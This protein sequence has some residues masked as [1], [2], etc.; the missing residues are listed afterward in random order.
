MGY[1]KRFADQIWKETPEERKER[2]LDNDILDML[3]LPGISFKK[4][5]DRILDEMR[6]S[7]YDNLVNVFDKYFGSFVVLYR[8]DYGVKFKA[9]GFTQEMIDWI[10][11]GNVVRVSNDRYLEQTSQWKRLFTKLELIEYFNKEFKNQ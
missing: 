9:M 8:Q 7:D 4:M 5:S 11:D 6:E 1:A 3:D 10:E 2:M